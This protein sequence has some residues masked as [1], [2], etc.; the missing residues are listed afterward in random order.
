MTQLAV[1]LFFSS[2]ALSSSLVFSAKT[3]K[4]LSPTIQQACLDM[5]NGKEIV[6]VDVSDKEIQDICKGEGILLTNVHHYDH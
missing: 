4:P 1:A 6:G 3:P 2:L 5:R